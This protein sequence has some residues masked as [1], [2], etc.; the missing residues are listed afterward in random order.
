M[1]I[2]KKDLQQTFT[3]AK[4]TSWEMGSFILLLFIFV[5]KKG[6]LRI[7]G[8]RRLPTVIHAG[9]DRYKNRLSRFY[10]DAVRLLD[11]HKIGAISRIDLIE[12]SIKNIKVKR[13]RTIVTI[14]G[15]T[16]GIGIIVFLVSLGYGLE[17][18]VIS[19]VARL[20]EMKQ[21]DVTAHAGSKARLTDKTIN[22][23]KE[24]TNVTE[25]LPLIAVVG[26]V[27]YQNSFSDMAVYGV[28]T[29]YF[30]QSAI[31]P[32]RGTV[33]KSTNLTVRADTDS[34]KVAGVSTK[35]ET[36]AYGKDIG[37]VDF[38]INPG[39]WIR[40][41]EN[42]GTQSKILGYTKRVEGKNLGVETWGYQYNDNAA[43]HAG[44][45]KDG[46]VLGK[47][48]KAPFLLWQ[49]KFCDSQ[50]N[51]D[52]E[53]GGYVVMRDKDNLQVS[54]T[55]Y[56]A[57]ISMVLTVAQVESPVVLGVSTDVNSASSSG[58]LGWV[59]IASESATVQPQPVKT[60]TPLSTLKK[61]A[62]VNRAMLK[63]LGIKESDAV[64]KTFDASFVV[65][66][67][68]LADANTRVESVP[69]EYTIVGV[70]PDEKTPVFYVPFINLRSLGIVNYSQLKTVVDKQGDLPL[71]RKKIEAL[72][73]TTRSVVDTVAQINSLFSTAR[74]LLA[75]LGVIALTVAALGMFNTLTVSLLE[76]T[77][78]VGLMKAMG[79]KSEE[80]QELF[81][82]ESMIMGLSGG[83]LGILVGFLAGK[84][85][86]VFLSFFAIFKGVGFVDVSYTPLTLIV[87]IIFLSLVVGMLTGLYPAKRAT[88]ISALDAL[89][90]E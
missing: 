51:G 65:M 4:K 87:G 17:R 6:L 69:A 60:V 33:F 83:I 40:V 43:G 2:T 62:V 49:K 12:L 31:K 77:R 19:R 36:A 54:Q 47:W 23:I 5:S 68:L 46:E 9:I 41:R 26:K 90:Y 67:D 74:V 70:T 80:I 14:G 8:W 88:K 84:A 44:L 16:L 48:L 52:C 21:T 7:Y 85:L 55:G 15:M 20:D 18:L 64:G 35:S 79:M 81:L 32:V 45:D 89:R 73:Y 24:M 27:S 37:K 86:G 82:T 57:E 53:A 39:E 76:R 30:N 66:G 58:G 3:I 38:S 75:L 28:T 61:E 42:P 29:E 13:T 10:D 63:I 1:K 59:E 56:V 50:T 25:T 71:V 34:G 72:G 22:D 11:T 78:E